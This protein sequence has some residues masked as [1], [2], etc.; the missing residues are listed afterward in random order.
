MKN[1]SRLTL[2]MT[3]KEHTYLK[4]ISAKLGITM[5]EFIL[6]AAFKQME[7]IEDEWLS[8]KARK[9]LKDIDSGKE[10]TISWNEMKK[11]IA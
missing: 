5:K 11:R 10:K 4:M 1:K 6:T 7:E 3:Q 9:V 2:D 8:D